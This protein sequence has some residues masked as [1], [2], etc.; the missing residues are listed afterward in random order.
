M[1]QDIEEFRKW[2][3]VVDWF[4]KKL[5]TYVRIRMWVIDTI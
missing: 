4:K 5:I 3:I 1:T 2:R